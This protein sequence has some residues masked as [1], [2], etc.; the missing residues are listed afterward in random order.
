MAEADDI[1]AK[2][3][4]YNRKKDTAPGKEPEPAPLFEHKLVYDSTAEGLEPVYFWLLDFLQPQVDEVIKINDNF[5]ASPGSGYFSEIGARMTKMQEEGMK[6]LGVVNQVVKSVINLI[7]DMKEFEI[8][9]SYYK[10]LDKKETKKEGLLALKQI[11]MDNVDIKRGAG[12]I[13]RM[14]Y[15]L[16]FATLRDAFMASDSVGEVQK[17]ELN[18]RVRRVL[19]PRVGEFL[20]WVDRSRAEI[21]KRFEIEKSYLKSQV[22]TLRLYSKWVRPY[23]KSAEEL[24]MRDVEK[25]RRPWMVSAFNTMVLELSILGAKEIKVKDAVDTKVLPLKFRRMDEKKKFRKT[26]FIVLIDFAFRGIPRRVPES[27]YV[28]GGRVEVKFRC[29]TMNEDELILFKNRLNKSDLTSSL[30]LAQDVSDESMDQLIHDIEHFT[31]KKEEEKEET[32]EDLNPFTALLGIKKRK[33]EE[34]KEES[35]KVLSKDEMEEKEIAEKAAKIEKEKG[36]KP[37]SYEE[38]VIRKLAEKNSIDMGFSLVDKYKKAHG[39]AAFPGAPPKFEI[40]TKN[41][42]F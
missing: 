36:P 1:I 5:S 41:P 14:T 42:Y 30:K 23:L 24:R 39:M 3:S 32:D 9:I 20:E 7:Y 38:S 10:K 12:S 35:V 19:E 29:Y 18:D 16:G 37:D 13:N 2:V 17:W 28:H 6:I 25:S 27:H 22:S 8:R 33:K 11:W 15:E 4:A 21:T 31:E 34:K 40:P 26:F